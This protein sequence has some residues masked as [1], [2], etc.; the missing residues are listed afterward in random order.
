MSRITRT[1]S[2]SHRTNVP[3]RKY[4]SPGLFSVI[5]RPTRIT[6]MR[7]RTDSSS[8]RNTIWRLHSPHPPSV[9]SLSGRLQDLPAYRPIPLGRGVGPVAGQ[10]AHLNGHGRRRRS[11]SRALGGWSGTTTGRAARHAGRAVGRGCFYRGGPGRRRAG[12]A[13]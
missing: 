1:A 7:H 6:Q 11:R 5:W 12:G 4:S 9:W 13:A 2:R 10:H 8:L 3:A